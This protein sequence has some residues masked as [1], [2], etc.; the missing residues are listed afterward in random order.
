MSLPFTSSY[1]SVEIPYSQK[2][3]ILTANDY[4][5]KF[6]NPSIKIISVDYIRQSLGSND[7]IKYLVVYEKR[8]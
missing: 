8:N 6:Y 4:L 2:K 3:E 5:K 1:F 7:P